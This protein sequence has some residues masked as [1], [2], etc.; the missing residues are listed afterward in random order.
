[1]KFEYAKLLNKKY[2]FKIEIYKLYEPQP[3]ENSISDTGNL[4][5]TDAIELER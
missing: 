4:I 3:S 1:M 5:F 2:L